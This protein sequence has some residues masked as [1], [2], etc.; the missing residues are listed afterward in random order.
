MKTGSE[1]SGI[2][3]FDSPV[4]DNFLQVEA[5]LRE[6]LKVCI[7]IKRQSLRERRWIRKRNTGSLIRGF[8]GKEAALDKL[9]TIDG[10]LGRLRGGP[11]PFSGTAINDGN[12]V[13]EVEEK[14]LHILSEIDYINKKNEEML[15]R[16]KDEV[17]KEVGNLDRSVAAARTYQRSFP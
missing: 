3:T 11:E 2:F 12:G 17:I 4:S 5:L 16:A 15:R 13:T 6:K 8:E 14:I 1:L 9:E 7:E 10:E